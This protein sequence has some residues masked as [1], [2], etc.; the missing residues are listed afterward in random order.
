MD[1]LN[2]RHFRGKV[3]R[4]Q[5]VASLLMGL[6]VVMLVWLLVAKYEEPAWMYLLAPII[7]YGLAASVAGIAVYLSAC[8][9]GVHRWLGSRTFRKAIDNRQFSLAAVMPT[10]GMLNFTFFTLVFWVPYNILCKIFQ[11]EAV[12]PYIPRSYQELLQ[13]VAQ[14][15]ILN[16]DAIVIV[17]LAVT[18][19]PTSIYII[20]RLREDKE[21]RGQKLEFLQ[22]LFYVSLFIPVLAYLSW[23]YGIIS[24]DFAPYFTVYRNILLL[25]LLPGS[26]GGAMVFKTFESV[27]TQN[28][29]QKE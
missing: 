28:R 2:L 27:E 29:T 19:G 8:L 14:I 3:S 23:C 11:L 13:A 6:I 16:L 25:I 18:F 21:D 4:H 20:R 24:Y 15:K 10:Y 17:V 7:L 22:V 5:T 26:I 1:A 12:E 9:L